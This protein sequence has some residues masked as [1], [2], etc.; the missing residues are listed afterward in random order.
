M[1]TQAEGSSTTPYNPVVGC[2]GLQPTGSYVLVE[3]VER[4]VTSKS[5]LA[6]PQ[7]ANRKSNEGI[8][9]ALGPGKR[10]FRPDIAERNSW[11][12][13]EAQALGARGVTLDE[14]EDVW[15]HIPIDLSIGDRVLYVRW[16]GYMVEV[17]SK[18][19]FLVEDSNIVC[20]ATSDTSELAFWQDRH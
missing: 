9:R 6:F 11:R 14:L 19:Y 13:Q 8:V 12:C 1:V 3:P 20:V 17:D 4:E 7:T 18:Q 10:E 16:A 15:Q 5:G 2:V